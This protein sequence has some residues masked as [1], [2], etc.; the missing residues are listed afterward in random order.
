MP[1]WGS[2][3]SLN[4]KVN[5][6][7]KCE[8]G[9]EHHLSGIPGTRWESRRPHSWRFIV[10]YSS[11]QLWNRDHKWGR[12]AIVRDVAD[13]LI[14]FQK[15]ATHYRKNCTFWCHSSVYLHTFL[16]NSVWHW[17]HISD[18]ILRENAWEKMSVQSVQMC[19]KYQ[20]D[21]VNDL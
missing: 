21:T 5:E 8:A 7:L 4:V 11:P 16:G 20:E 6:H 18:A 9:T 17:R 3:G 19:L 12:D 10:W 1:P 2:S 15:N 13:C 14:N